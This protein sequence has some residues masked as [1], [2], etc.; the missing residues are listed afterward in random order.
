MIILPN[1]SRDL[2]KMISAIE[3]QTTEV[4]ELFESH[5]PQALLWRP[6]DRKWSVT[7]HVAHLCIVNE[8]YTGAMQE[9]LMKNKHR[10]SGGPDKHPW[11][12]RFF[13][14]QMAPPVKWRM[15][16]FKE[17]VPDPTLAGDDV[18]E[19]FV[20][21]QGD[22]AQLAEDS[23]GIDLGKARFGSPYFRLLRHSLGTGLATLEAHNRRHLWLAEE[24]IDWEG[25]PG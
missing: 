18:L 12:G 4:R 9:C 16:T 5:A 11:A 20:R 14:R 17:M 24:V 10:T 13:A 22:L 1:C 23:T 2:A 15:K 19:R 21:T 25:F 8:G 7:G 6:N 3:S